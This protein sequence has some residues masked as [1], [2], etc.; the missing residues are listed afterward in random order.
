MIQIKEKAVKSS[1]KSKKVLI[2]VHNHPLI[3]PGGSE[4]F[5]YDLFHSI[6]K[7]TNY[8]GF[9]LAAS[10]GS[11]RQPRSNTPFQTV[12]NAPD[13]IL[14]WGGVFDYF[15]QSQ[16][17]PR[18]ASSYLRNFLQQLQ[19]DVV[20]FHHSLHI[21]LEVVS[22]VRQALPKAKIV[23]T[24]HEFLLIC[25]R[26]GQMVFNHNNDL[27]EY[28]SPSKCNRCFPEI[29]P[30]K[31]RMREEFIKA[32]LQLVDKFVSPSYFLANRFEDWGISKSKIIV[33]ENGRK[34]VEPA[35]FRN[36]QEDKKRNVFGF[37]GQINPYKGVIFALDAVAYLIKNKFTDFRLELFGSVDT[38]SPEFQKEFFKIV[39]R[40][41]NNVTFH[42]R[43]RN[44]EMSELIQ[45]VDWVIVPSTWWENSPL[46]IQEVFMHKRPII[47]SNIGGMAEK[48]KHNV[49][50]L[51]FKVKNAVSLAKTMR[52]ATL[53][54]ELWEKL[55]QN[56]EPRLS[57]KQCAIEHI[58]LYENL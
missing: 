45:Q 30:Q 42:G 51:H 20:H 28:A 14:F 7:Y 16:K 52:K 39:D 36:N 24:L 44:N 56:I 49:T 13:E 43:Y 26:D 57:I 53:Q 9:F 8:D 19:P 11:H 23:Y 10:N 25:N 17:N 22:L 15:Y 33:L 29:S 41:K 18:L 4:I 21:G 32:H 40:Y 27:C 54:T 55:V 35:P 47:C 5:A 6:K 34:L 58:S 31:F 2:V 3:S 48:V 50:G 12:N 38:Q 46:V 1:T 37:F